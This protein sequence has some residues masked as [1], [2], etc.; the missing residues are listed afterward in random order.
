MDSQPLNSWIPQSLLQ[1]ALLFTISSSLKMLLA[2]AYFS[3]D[4]DVHQNWL[5]ITGHKP[6]T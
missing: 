4:M 3:T 2:P 1:L 5:R 6:L